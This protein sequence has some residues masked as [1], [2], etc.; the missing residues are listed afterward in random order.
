MKYKVS[1]TV[2][3]T[4]QYT[5]DACSEVEAILRAQDIYLQDVHFNSPTYEEITWGSDK[6][7]DRSIRKV[8]IS[9][10]NNKNTE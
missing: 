6:I 7:M 8:N 10:I 1:L 2:P 4:V 9:S 5:V 3:V